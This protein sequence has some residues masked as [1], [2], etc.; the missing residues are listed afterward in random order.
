M[1]RKNG[2]GV[3]ML[4]HIL[5]CWPLQNVWGGIFLNGKI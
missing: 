4:W 3:C 1:T 2:W 5:R